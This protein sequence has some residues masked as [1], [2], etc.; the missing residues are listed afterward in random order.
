[1][2]TQN[3]MPTWATALSEK[4]K[5]TVRNSVPPVGNSSS[6]STARSERGYHAA[7]DEK[8]IVE[9]DQPFEPEFTASLSNFREVLK[10]LQASGYIHLADL[11]AYDESPVSP[12]FKVIYELISMKDKK[13]CAVIVPL[14]DVDPKIQTVTDL[15]QGANWLERETYDMYGIVFENHPDLRRMLLPNSF[16]GY[17]LRKDF[18]VDYRQEFDKSLIDEGMFDPFGNT[19]V[20]GK[21]QS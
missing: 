6:K 15:W 5:L 11:T 8:Q 17:P 1:M 20:R 10:D 16:K 7:P 4:Y 14:S 19:L 2:A 21:T 13:R 12:R 3:D 18:I 9:I